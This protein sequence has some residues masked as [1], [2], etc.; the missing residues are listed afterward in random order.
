VYPPEVPDYHPDSEIR[1][2]IDWV[3]SLK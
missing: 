1:A 2:L 3:L